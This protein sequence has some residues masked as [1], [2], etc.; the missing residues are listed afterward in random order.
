MPAWVLRTT[1]S[2]G[3]DSDLVLAA[4]ALRPAVTTMFASNVSLYP[5]GG[6]TRTAVWR[7]SVLSNACSCWESGGMLRFDKIFRPR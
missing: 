2:E 1:G 3:T 7:A 5:K 4:F 6:V